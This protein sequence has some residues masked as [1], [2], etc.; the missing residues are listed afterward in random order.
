MCLYLKHI[1]YKSMLSFTADIF[2]CC[3][4]DGL[5]CSALLIKDHSIFNIKIR[6]TASVI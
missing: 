1:P 2:R 4:L 5:T 3:T 6:D